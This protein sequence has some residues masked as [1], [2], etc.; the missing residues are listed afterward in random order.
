MD[1]SAWKQLSQPD[2]PAMIVVLLR[3]KVRQITIPII[4][5]RLAKPCF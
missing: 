1:F 3:A 5:I 2:I 4:V